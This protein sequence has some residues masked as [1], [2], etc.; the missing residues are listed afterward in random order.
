MQCL[1][2][3]FLLALCLIFVGQSECNSSPLRTGMLTG[4][5]VET[6]VGT[7]KLDGGLSAVDDPVLSAGAV[8][9]VAINT[10]SVLWTPRR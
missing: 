2:V 6:V 8:A 3:E 10:T 1:T 7:G 4:A 9:V 5:S